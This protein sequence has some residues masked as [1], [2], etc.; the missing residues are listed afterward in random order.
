MRAAA[1][2]GATLTDQLLAF[3]RR[4]PLSPRVVD[5]NAL[6]RGMADLLQSAIGNGIVMDMRLDDATWPAMVDPTQI[7][8]RSSTSPSTPATPWA[9]PAR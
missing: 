2:R 8:P 7:E 5:V 4:Q 3:A 9:R 1:E 6:V